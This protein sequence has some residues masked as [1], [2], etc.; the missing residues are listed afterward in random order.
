MI[1]RRFIMKFQKYVI[2]FRFL[3]HAKVTHALGRAGE[4]DEVAKSIVFLAS[5]AL[6]SFITGVN[7]PVDG[8]RGMY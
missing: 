6:S 5:N 4:A 3:E 1:D 7:M 2:L 8:G